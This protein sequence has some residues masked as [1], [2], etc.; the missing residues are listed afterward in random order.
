ML[1]LYALAREP[2]SLPDG[3]VRLHSIRVADGIAA[4]VGE[5]ETAPLRS[6]E[7]AVLSHAHVVDELAQ[8]NAS[9][10]PARF[11]GDYADEGSLR[12]A[13]AP[14][15]AAVDAALRRVAGCVEIG[16]RVVETDRDEGPAAASGGEYM[17]TRLRLV[18]TGER[19]ADELHTTLAAAARESTKSVLAT[20]R[21][22]FSGTYLVPKT[23][24]DEFRELVARAETAHDGIA[25]VC[26]GPWPVYS[27]GLV[28]DER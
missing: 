18:Q 22:V 21:L 14:R 28:G 26:T 27:F 1:H 23:E 15:A 6:D 19:L 16:V 5:V 8:T 11:G 4:V 3:E 9:V 25:V 12:A 17:R 24:I 10:L 2:V 13:F 20:P 7:A